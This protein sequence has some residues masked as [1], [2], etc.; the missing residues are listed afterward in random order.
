M[1]TGEMP[2]RAGLRHNMIAPYGAYGCADGAVLFGIQNEREWARF[3]ADVL[4]LAHWRRIDFPAT[5]YASKIA[6]NW[7]CIIEATFAQLTRAEVIARLDRAG[8]ANAAMND[9]AE[10]AQH[11][12]LAARHR[13]AEAH[14]P[15][16]PIRALLP[17]HNL[18][19]APPVMGRCPGLG[20]T[21]ARSWLEGSSNDP[22]Q[23]VV[24]SRVAPDMIEKAAE[25]RG[26]RSLHRSGRLRRACG[27]T[28]RS[29]QRRPSFGAGLPAC[30]PQTTSHVPHQRARHALR[31]SRPDRSRGG[32]RRPHRS[33][34]AA[35]NQFRHG[36][37][38]RRH[39]AHANRDRAG[40]RAAHRHRSPDR[41][42]RRIPQCPRNRAVVAPPGSADLRPRRFRRVDAHAHGEHRRI[43]CATTISTP[44]T[45]GMP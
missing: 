36:C 16:G 25:Q 15:V 20:R 42:R 33:R 1:G 45:D 26:R 12:Q 23:H 9:T 22:A 11:P 44:A 29:R 19:D 27:Q 5:R 43:R 34:H 10:A 18:H 41:N 13:W 14:S 3:C 31:V 40:F 17:P 21:H 32:R 4:E 37:A 2:A 24:C 28:R 38:I 30:A 6:R 35:Q 8:I 7:S 39:A